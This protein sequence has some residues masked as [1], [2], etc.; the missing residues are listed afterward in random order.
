MLCFSAQ[1]IHNSFKP[2]IRED[3]EVPSDLVPKLLHRF[4][5]EEGYTLFPDVRPLLQTLRN[6]SNADDGRVF[7]GVITNS[8]PRVPD[9][10]SALGLRAS[11]LRYGGAV[12]GEMP[13]SEYDVDFTIMSY[14]VG[15]EKPDRRIFE[16]AEGMLATKLDAK[17][18]DCSMTRLEEWQKVYIGDEFEKDVVG[19]LNAGWDAIL[20]DRDGAGKTDD[21]E[22]LDEKE[23]SGFERM[24]ASSRAVGFSSLAKLAAWFPKPKL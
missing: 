9:V 23:P 6:H 14:D 3:Q 11:P 18:E 19:A 22:W 13:I 20:I 7:V 12:R 5:S 4:W 10:L 1:I 16:A 2:I 8:D 24:F 15:H 21:V 17:G